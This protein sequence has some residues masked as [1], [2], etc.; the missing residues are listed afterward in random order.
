M[1]Y[2]LYYVAGFSITPDEFAKLVTAPDEEPGH[3][4]YRVVLWEVT[5]RTYDAF[6]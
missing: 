6:R 2:A 1:H 4:V 3:G 5:R